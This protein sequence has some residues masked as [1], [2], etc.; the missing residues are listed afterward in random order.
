MPDATIEAV[1]LGALDCL[2][3]P[4]DIDRLRGVLTT[5]V[6]STERR[7]VLQ[8]PTSPGR[9]EPEALEGKRHVRPISH[10]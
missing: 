4:S 1:K 9:H 5:V 8:R 2:S 6:K 10:H 7:E 3:S